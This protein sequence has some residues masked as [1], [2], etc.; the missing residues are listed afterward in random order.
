MAN[1]NFIP[2]NEPFRKVMGN[3]ILY[4]VPMFQRDYSWT[5]TQWDDLWLDIVDINKTQEPT[6][7]MGY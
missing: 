2:L 1:I 5:E 7:Y 4:T 6:H 3:G